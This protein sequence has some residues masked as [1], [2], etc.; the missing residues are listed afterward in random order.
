MMIDA[1]V[2]A[3]SKALVKISHPSMFFQLPPICD[4]CISGEE[5]KSMEE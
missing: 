3:K 4:V 1:D 5:N 2:K